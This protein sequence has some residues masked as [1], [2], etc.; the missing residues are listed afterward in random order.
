MLPWIVYFIT[1]YL[2]GFHVQE[3]NEY[4]V[5][6][7]SAIIHDALMSKDENSTVTIQISDIAIKH[8]GNRQSSRI[9]NWYIIKNASRCYALFF[10]RALELCRGHNLHNLWQLYLARSI[11]TSQ[12]RNGLH[13]ATIWESLQTLVRQSPTGRTIICQATYCRRSC[14]SVSF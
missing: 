10:F 6:E 14:L 4:T 13:Q 7:T 9:S 2:C 11:S 3:Y 1:R 8:I 12:P 5:A